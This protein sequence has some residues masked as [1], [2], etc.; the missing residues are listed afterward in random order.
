MLAVCALLLSP[1]SPDAAELLRRAGE[2]IV[3][4]E[5]F[6]VR[7]RSEQAAGQ[8]GPLFPNLRLDRG[9]LGRWRVDHGIPGSYWVSDGLRWLVVNGPA[10]QYRGASEGPMTRGMRALLQRW[11]LRFENLPAMAAQGR[12]LRDE[13][14]ERGARRIRCALVEVRSGSKANPWRERL[15]IELETALIWQAEF[16]PRSL[17]AAPGRAAD[18]TGPG[19]VAIRGAAVLSRYDWIAVDRPESGVDFDVRPPAGYRP[20]PER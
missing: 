15:W 2:R 17:E 5:G 10:R 20:A 13:T 16:D 11:I 6:S 1:P 9:D 3:A 19:M 8:A 4:M 7:I 12:F 18:E 14:L